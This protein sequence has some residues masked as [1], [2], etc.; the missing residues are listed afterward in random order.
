MAAL[1][2]GAI[3]LT[4][5]IGVYGL[6]QIRIPEL[7]FTFAAHFVVGWIFLIGATYK[8]PIKIAGVNPFEDRAA[9]MESDEDAEAQNPFQPGKR[10][11]KA[12]EKNPFK[13]P[14]K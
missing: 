1:L 7:I 8:L 14:K 10:S 12:P 6:G 9:E 3:L 13:R 5:A 11:G 2:P 4:V